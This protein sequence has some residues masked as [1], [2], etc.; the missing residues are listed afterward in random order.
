MEGKEKKGGGG[1][2]RKVGMGGVRGEATAIKSR[3]LGRAAGVKREKRQK[4]MSIN[5]AGSGHGEGETTG[6]SWIV[7]LIIIGEGEGSGGL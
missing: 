4:L 7:I 2:G 6:G 5:C 3:G 1:G